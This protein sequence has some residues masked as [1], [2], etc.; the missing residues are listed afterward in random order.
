MAEISAL[1]EDNECLKQ[2]SVQELAHTRKAPST[3]QVFHQIKKSTFLDEPHYAPCAGG[4]AVLCADIPIRGDH[5]YLS[6]HPE[7]AFAVYKQYDDAPDDL[8]KIEILDGV[9]RK[10]TPISECILLTALEIE[11]AL[12][13]LVEHAPAF[14]EYFQDFDFKQGLVEHAPAFFEYF[15]DFDFKQG[16]VEH[17]PAFFEYFQDFDFKQRLES[18][19]LFMFYM[20]PFL[21]QILPNPTMPKQEL[22]QHLKKAIDDRHG[23]EYELARIEAEKGMVSDNHL[24]YLIRPGDN[25]HTSRLP[26]SLDDLS[27]SYCAYQKLSE[28]FYA[29]VAQCCRCSPCAQ[30][31]RQ[32]S[33]YWHGRANYPKASRKLSGSFFFVRL[34]HWP[35][36]RRGF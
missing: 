34:F 36:R 12:Q 11:D 21:P 3:G 33:G 22:V 19:C 4:D 15:Q 23:R 26:E 32:P 13:G 8:S 24:K 10:P 18:P 27:A 5:L 7:I 28:D 2:G 9:Y 17:A 31:H 6:Q 35:S 29:H 16:L 1:R 20:S 25:C 30:R 14:F